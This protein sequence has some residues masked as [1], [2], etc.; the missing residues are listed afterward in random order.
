M[1][2]RP[3]QPHSLCI[4]IADKLRELILAHRLPPGSAVNDG[5][6]ARE[7][8]VSRTPVREAMKLLCHEGL[9]T[10]QARR[11]MSVTVLSPAQI[12]EARRLHALLGELLQRH[13]SENT[14]QELTRSMHGLAQA[15][16]QL[17]QG[18]DPAENQF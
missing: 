13:D 4:A 10:A 12:E 11:G 9:L 15:R 1:N 16:L 5:D 17:A 8:G 3:L 7:F 14:P 2:V 18:S 6:L